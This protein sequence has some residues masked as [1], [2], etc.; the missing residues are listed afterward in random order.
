MKKLFIANGVL[1][2]LCLGLFIILI[3]TGQTWPNTLLYEKAI[4]LQ[5]FLVT[6][7][8][9]LIIISFSLAFTLKTFKN[10]LSI[11]KLCLMNGLLITSLISI[12]MAYLSQDSKFHARFSDVN[13]THA[14]IAKKDRHA[15]NPEFSS[16][17]I[18]HY[19]YSDL[20]NYYNTRYTQDKKTIK[21][22]NTFKNSLTSL[23]LFLLSFTSLS[24]FFYQLLLSKQVIKKSRTTD[25]QDSLENP[26]EQEESP[27]AF[28]DISMH[29][30]S[31]QT[32]S[33]DR[34]A[35]TFKVPTQEFDFDEPEYKVDENEMKALEKSYL[36]SE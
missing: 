20:R 31:A 7:T 4:T 34:D 25:D 3:F 5:S 19:Y 17:A 22:S 35:P 28:Q 8:F 12:Y 23:S 16:S 36:E 24:S 15:N 1:W 10:K 21:D 2:A 11:G 18:Q 26:I 32:D 27:H 29:T 13:T 33:F 30:N 14:N 6:L 9:L